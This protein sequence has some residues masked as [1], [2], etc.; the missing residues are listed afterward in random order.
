[1]C[2]LR[3]YEIG[4]YG[5]ITGQHIITKGMARGN[6]EV[7]KIL[8]ACPEEIMAPVCLGHNVTKYADDK[9][10]RAILIFNR[11]LLLGFRRVDKFLREL[12]WKQQYYEYTL[13]GLLAFL[14]P[15]YLIQQ[16]INKYDPLKFKSP[17]DILRE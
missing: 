10:A 15:P 5:R 9:E 6:L 7:R 17:Y 8:V 12:P 3:G 14:P 13:P 16:M 1:M 11:C 2:E 4:C